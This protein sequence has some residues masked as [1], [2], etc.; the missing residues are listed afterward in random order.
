MR[1]ALTAKYRYSSSA[2]IHT[3]A[4]QAASSANALRSVIGSALRQT[5]SSSLPSS[6]GR[7][8]AFGAA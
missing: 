1:L 3:A 5:A 4:G 8:A 2:A 6:T 7:S